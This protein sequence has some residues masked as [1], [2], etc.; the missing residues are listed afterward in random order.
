[1]MKYLA[2]LMVILS[3]AAGYYY[4]DL[5]ATTKAQ[6][7]ELKTGERML[8][9]YGESVTETDT[10]I[11]NRPVRVTKIKEIL[12]Y[13]DTECKV[14]EEYADQLNKARMELAK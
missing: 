12:V 10:L 6:T 11:E 3:F 7:L 2:A 13:V 4:A 1:M 5:K 9:M 8:E 14:T